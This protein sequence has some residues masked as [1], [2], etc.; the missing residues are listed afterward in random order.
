MGAILT[1][2]FW[3]AIWKKTKAGKYTSQI[4]MAVLLILAV[5]FAWAKIMSLKNERAQIAATLASEKMAR[6]T[7]V[8]AIESDRDKHQ[9][10]YENQAKTSASL[11]SRLE[12]TRRS[13]KRWKSIALDGTVTEYEEEIEE[14]AANTNESASEAKA[15]VLPDPT[16]I[17]T[18]GAIPTSVLSGKTWMLAGSYAVVAEEWDAALYRT[19]DWLTIG[20]GVAGPEIAGTASAYAQL[21]P[22]GVGYGFTYPIEHLVR[23]TVSF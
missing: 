3:R 6:A 15:P 10:A 9:A 22:F 5:L 7:Q 21:G 8:A 19:F 11:K 23:G 1:K 13:S 14:T 17:P 2:V 4:A 18:I 16:T 12:R 20:A